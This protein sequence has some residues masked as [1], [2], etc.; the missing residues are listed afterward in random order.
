MFRYTNNSENV[1]IETIK[2]QKN[3]AIDHKIMVNDAKYPVLN[4][5]KIF[6]T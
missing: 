2:L 6:D 4:T 3:N 1:K 5:P